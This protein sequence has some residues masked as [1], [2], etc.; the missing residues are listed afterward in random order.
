MVLRKANTAYGTVEGIPAGNPAYTTFKGVPFAAPPVGALRWAAPVAPQ[1]W[2]GVRRCDTFPP[3][4][5]QAE[6]REGDFYQREFFPTAVP[7]SEDCLYLNIWTPAGSPAEGLPVMAWIHGG[8][9]MQG[10]SY[11]ME[12]DGEA[13]CKQGVILVTIGYRLGALGFMAH[14]ELSRRGPHGVSGNYG[15][16]D[17]IQALR[18]IKENI[19]AFGGDPGNVTVFGQSAGGAAVQAIVTSPLGEGLVHKAIVQ[20]AGGIT[21]I[22][23]KYTLAQGEELGVEICRQA[24]TSLDGLRA[25]PAEAVRAAAAAVMSA[26]NSAMPRRRLGQVVDGY[27]LP[28]APGSLVAAGKH[29]A[30][31]YMTGSVAGDG[32]MFAG[33]T[34]ESV[35]DFEQSVRAQYG[36]D[37][38]RYLA[39]F[40]V[41][42]EADLAAVQVA[43]KKAAS[44]LGPRGWARAHQRQGRQGPY[45]Y[46]FDRDIPGEDHPGAFHSSELWYIFGT[47]ARCWRPMQAVDYGI[48]L[49]MT[50]Y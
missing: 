1:P 22:G 44:L 48:S 7:M 40:D 49:Q 15:I 30:I 50:A 25:L 38:E 11:E 19:S 27:V 18:W 33:R 16:L 23:G 12:F 28:E 3:I 36:A 43:R 6:Q 35:A 4:S 26:S 47:L 42:S 29:L 10:Y 45:I 39:L 41:H 21:T 8:A 9:F 24:G 13:F 32:G 34:V 5:I 14:P 37:A 46:Y 31:P 17:C 2:S 20:S